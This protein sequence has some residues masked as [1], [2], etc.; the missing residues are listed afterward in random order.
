MK[1]VEIQLASLPCQLRLVSA[2]LAIEGEHA[3][4]S[5]AGNA[6]F[7]AN[8]SSEFLNAR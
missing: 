3:G 5:V 2:N 6:A 8:T 1:P 4:Q 7:N